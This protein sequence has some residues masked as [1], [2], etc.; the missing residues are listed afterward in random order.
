MIKLIKP[1]DDTP[2]L[3]EL[4]IYLSNAQRDITPRWGKMSGAEMLKHCNNFIN[5]YLGEKTAPLL[6]RLLARL[7]GKVF[8]KK[9]LKS[10]PTDTP[11]N[12]NTLSTIKVTEQNLE[13]D[14]ERLS[15]NESLTKIEYIGGIIKHPLYGQMYSEDVVA[16]IRH[17]TAHHFNQFGLL[18]NSKN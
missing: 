1:T 18:P 12:L 16:L 4:K 10:S 6:I 8:L 15:L 2:S 5:L 11:K 7:M 14:A 17:H 3:G 13:F 9:I